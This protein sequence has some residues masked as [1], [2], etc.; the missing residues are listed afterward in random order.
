MSRPKVAPRRWTPPP[1]PPRARRTTGDTPFPPMELIP[2][3]GEAPEDVVVDAAGRLYTGL[4]G[5]RVVRVDPATRAV[6]VVGDT[7][8]RPLGLEAL[9]DGRLLVCDS[10]RG[11]LRLDPETGDVETL[12]REVGGRPLVFCSNAVAMADGTVWFSESSRRFGFE[13]YRADLVEHSASGRVFRLDPDGTVETVVDGLRFANGLALAAD[14]SYLVVAET[15][16]YSL[17]RLWLAGERQGT[18]E[19]W[20]TNLPGFPDNIARGT[21]GLVWVTLPNARNPVLDWALPRS[22]WLRRAT[23][24]LPERLQPQPKRT[25]W[26]LGV[27]PAGE[28]VRD[29]Q[30]DGDRWAFAT[31]VAEHEGRLYLASIAERSLA[32]LAP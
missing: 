19:P 30:G 7:G 25:V 22:P 9:P 24:A 27:S 1:A 13:H 21:G 4:S 8:G 12:V 5:G 20:V 10:H 2:L 18:Y 16:G 28:V 14:E 15:A 29:Y 26:V 31:G 3:P 32:V 17:S 11:L 23:Y 6:T